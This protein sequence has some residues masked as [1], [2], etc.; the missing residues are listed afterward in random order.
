MDNSS[1]Q[2]GKS[3]LAIVINAAGD[4]IDIADV[5]AALSVPRTQASKLLSRWRAQGWLR[6]VGPGA[7][8]H[9]PLALRDSEQ[10]IQ[11]PWVLIPALFDPA[12]IGG[13]TAAEHWDLT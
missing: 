8:V 2:S 7:Y 10:V 11:D 5:E 13:W 3:R 1:H 12:Y 4:V 6:R 9:V